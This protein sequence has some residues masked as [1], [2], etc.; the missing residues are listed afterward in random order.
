MERSA[1]RQGNRQD[2]ETFVKAPAV[3]RSCST[4]CFE[5]ADLETSRRTGLAAAA[6]AAAVKAAASTTAV[7]A[8]A[9]A[10]A[11]NGRF[12]TDLSHA[13]DDIAEISLAAIRFGV[14]NCSSEGEQ[15][16]SIR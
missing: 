9:S 10:A 15:H 7:K 12:K 2:S 3:R 5:L 11:D 1:G 13:V 16:P 4:T 6:S 8:A 14:N